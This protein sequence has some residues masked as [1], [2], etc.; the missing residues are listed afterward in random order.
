MKSCDFFRITLTAVIFWIA[1]A[2]LFAAELEE[3]KD[4][5]KMQTEVIDQRFH[6]EVESL[7]R[8]YIGSIGNLANQAVE[9]GDLDKVLLLRETMRKFEE[10]TPEPV[11]PPLSENPDF[12]RLQDTWQRLYDEQLQNRA[13]RMVNLYQGYD[14]ALEQLQRRLTREG[15]I[16][17]ALTVQE[18]RRAV[19]ANEELQQMREMIKAIREDADT[20]RMPAPHAPVVPVMNKYAPQLALHLSFDRFE[21]MRNRVPDSSRARNH[22]VPHG[23]EWVARGKKGAA[24]QFD[25][26]QDRVVVGNDE[27]LQITGDQTIAF[28]IYPD[29]LD[30]RRNP[31]NKAYGG[32]GTITLEPDG[33]LNYY[34][35]TAGGNSHPYQ[36]F[37]SEKEIPLREWT[38]L[39]VV[40]DLT[41]GKLRWY[42]NGEQVAEADAQFDRARASSAPL[43]LGRGYAGSFQGMLDEVM[44]FSAALPP[45]DIQALYRAAGGE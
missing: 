33:R 16:E 38:H 24:M 40:R 15:Q 44:I 23:A 17:K 45:E 37:N 39:A 13:E 43:V 32:E 8:M 4:Y 42:M 21:R 11:G 25:G 7:K 5:L 34:Y 22:G 36:G 28:W 14:Q 27:S 9:E 29:V 12:A 10:E 26:G 2:D 1:P 20:P 3:F 30:A 31:L 41:G 19:A 18:E 6:H 35:G